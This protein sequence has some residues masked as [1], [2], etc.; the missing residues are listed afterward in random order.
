MGA[1]EWALLIALSLLWGAA[2]FLAK[3][4]VSEI[5]PVVLVFQRAG[6]AAV[7]LAVVLPILGQALPRGLALWRALLVMGLLNNA[8]PFGLLFWG[9]TEIG[10]GLAAMLNATTPLF[11]AVIARLVGQE[12]LTAGRAL[13]VA[14]GVG[15]VALMLSGTLGDNG[16]LWAEIACLGAAL[17]YGIAGVFGRR[18][19][20][21]VAP[22]AAAFGQLAASTALVL[23]VMLILTPAPWTLRPSLTVIGAIVAL[24]L[25][26]TALAYA[27]YFRILARAGATNLMLVT[28]LIPVSA[29]LLGG[30]FLGERLEARHFVG[31]FV[32]ALALAAM[33][34][35]PAAALRRSLA[36]WRRRS[37]HRQ[38]APRP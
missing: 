18:H 27:I 33:D 5:P 26:G 36:S 20:R 25:F 16:N 22:L 6:I 3:V 14:L 8:I 2:F 9:Q 31:M 28:V 23:P 21:G 10:S 32:I 37:D 4:S 17:S 34:G 7:A 35:R 38:A 29:A 15:G 30:L 1:R 24:A 11:S 12:R 19:L 13:G